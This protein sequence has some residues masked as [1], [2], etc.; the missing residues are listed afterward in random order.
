VKL[1]TIA[2]RLPE[3]IWALFEPLRPPVVWCGEGRPPASNHKCLHGLLQVLST[4]IGGA[5]VPPCFPGG[6]T[7]KERR[8]AWLE[9]DRFRTAWQQLAQRYEQLHSI[10]GDK[11]LRDGS[12]QPSTKG[13]PTPAPA[14]SIAPSAAPPSI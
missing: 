8:P 1:H 5:Y 6:R 2:R 13:G 10:N 9:G 7:L 4:G 3:E 14:P 12:K 11:I